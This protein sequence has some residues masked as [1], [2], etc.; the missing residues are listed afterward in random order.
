LNPIREASMTLSQ[1][2][3]DR[4]LDGVEKP[5]R[6]IG[7]EPNAVCKDTCRARLALCF[8]D[9]YEV[10]ESH[11]GLKILYDIVNHHSEF[12][13][14]R[15]YA[16]WPDLEARLRDRRVPLW[17][18]ETRQPLS[19]FDV[20]GFTL[21]HELS[22]PTMV[23]MLELGGIPVWS[24]QRGNND[25]L[26]IGGGSGA[27]NPEPIAPLLDAVYI[28]DGE[29]GILD[30]LRVVA[31]ARES[32]QDRHALLHQLARIDGIYIPA[33]FEVKTDG[34][35]TTRVRACPGTVAET[36]RTRRGLPRVSRRAIEDLDT[37]PYPARFI[38]PNIETV[39]ERVAIEI[40]RGCSRGCRFC[41]AGMATR[42]TRQRRPETVLR[43]ADAGLAAT[44]CD[45]V[46]LLSLS[47]GDYE[48]M[49]EVLGEFFR[50]YQD[51]RIAISLPSLRPETMTVGLA[52]QIASVRKSAFTFAPE[53]GSERLRRVINKTNTEADLLTAVDAAVRSGWR[54]LKLYFMIGLPTETDTDLE[55]I[56]LLADSVRRTAR[57]IRADASVTVSVSTFIPKPHTP[58]QWDEQIDIEETRRRQH[59]LR[60]SLRRRKIGFRYHSPEQSWVEGVLS[61]GDRRL[62]AAL[63]EAA[64]QGCRLDAWTEHFDIKRWRQAFRVALEPHGFSAAELL[65]ERDLDELLPWDH[66]DVG[67][68]KK[69]LRHDRKR[70]QREASVEDC[71]L[72]DRCY[73]C[74]ACDI[75]SPYVEPEPETGERVIRLRPQV[76]H[77]RGSH[78]S[79]ATPAPGRTASTVVA[80]SRL[81]FRVAKTGAAVHLSHLDTANQLLRA[82]RRS[83]LPTLY[84]EGHTPRPRIGFSPAC[85]TGITS[86]AEYFEVECAGFPEPHRYIAEL[87]R[88]LP[89]GVRVQQ[90]EQ[91]RAKTP[92]FNELLDN[93]RFRVTW[94]SPPSGAREAVAGFLAR[95]TV[96]VR[97][98]RKRK[99]KVVDARACIRDV[100][101]CGNEA[102]V[103]LAFG[104]GGTLKIGEALAALFGR[105]AATG[106]K[107]HKQ[108]VT[109]RASPHPPLAR[110]PSPPGIPLD[111][112]DLADRHHRPDG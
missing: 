67:V 25:P 64:R 47:A 100:Q 58:L 107:V 48:A 36:V 12:A 92:P 87:N 70:A 21:Q 29:E 71:A 61:R 3:L 5:A 68:L 81:R 38:V 73:A 112:T 72:A 37:A 76:H 40:Q 27:Y 110:Q 39:H 13:A 60:D 9:V 43:L 85:P 77:A 93:T 56:V 75:A 80:R 45:V 26:V 41:Q 91:L 51:D 22:Y 97:I 79:V 109:L 65:R 30:I 74:G 54:H 94:P 23:A 16:V 14:E 86:E 88:F 66:I 17:S 104:R 31:A 6:Y 15:V 44:G 69:F 42:P 57:A 105:D 90:G 35:R 8:P 59:L 101:L 108:A 1:A 63:V 111:L 96:P 7:G 11:I 102:E 95:D 62:A 10:A 49:A 4:L 52:E 99:G 50:R 55:A 32:G 78:H 46:S 24:D 2:E 106:A 53:A 18:L 19:A 83:G 98:R 89:E 33:Y 84:T 82:V 28:G 34:L 20:V 103:T